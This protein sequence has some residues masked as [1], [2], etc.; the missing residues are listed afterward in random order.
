MKCRICGNE[1]NS[2][3]CDSCGFIEYNVKTHGIANL[4]K[5][6]GNIDFSEEIKKVITFFKR[7][8][9]LFNSN[10]YLARSDYNS[11]LS[12]EKDN[13]SFFEKL[14]KSKDLKN[15]CLKFNFDSTNIKSYIELNKNFYKKVEEKNNDFIKKELLKRKDYFDNALKASNPSIYLDN[16]QRE[17][18]IKNEDYNLVVA[19]AGAGKTTTVEGK[20][21]YL[22]DILKVKPEDILLISFTNKAV[23]ELRERINDK[24]AIHCTI[25][26]F[27]STGVDV[28]K[29]DK[30]AQISKVCTDPFFPINDFLTKKVIE[31]KELLKKLVLMFGYYVNI[32]L[33]LIDGLSKEEYFEINER[34]DYSTL[35]SNLNE[36]VKKAINNVDKKMVTLQY[37]NVKSYQEVQIANFLYLNSIEYEYEKIYKYKIPNARKLY[38]PDFYIKQGDKE[39]YIEHFGLSE[40]GKN[41][42][43]S[44]EE[45]RKYKEEMNYKIFHH[46]NFGTN[47]ICTYSKYNDG[48]ELIDH[49]KDELIKAGFELKPRNDNEIYEKIVKIEKDK[50]VTSF[51]NL[52]SDFIH[53]FKAKGY[54][55]ENFAKLKLKT[56]NPRNLLFLDVLER[57]YLNYQGYLKENQAVD[58][59]DMINE[60]TRILNRLSEEGKK[61]NYKYIIVDEYQDISRQRFNL[62][63][64]LRKVCNAKIMAVGDD[65]QSIYAFS[66]SELPLFTKF[67]E[68]VG[69]ASLSRITKTYRNS[70]ELIDIAG[71]FIQK[72]D[73]QYKKS[74]KSDKHISKPVVVCTYNDDFKTNKKPGVAGVNLEKAKKVVEMIEKIVKVDGPKT[75]ILILGRYGFDEHFLLKSELFAKKMVGKE[76]KI[77]AVKYPKIL[78]TYMTAH[79][80]KGLTY[81]NVIIINAM[82]SKYGFPAQIEN[83]PIM[84]FVTNNDRSYDFAE[85]RR[86][87][88]VAMTRTKNRVFI[89]TPINNPSRFVIE[90]LND[91]KNVSLNKT[92][93]V[94]DE[95]SMEIKEIKKSR[96]YCPKCGYPL[97]LRFNEAYGLKLYMCTNDPEIC[98]FMTNNIKGNGNIHL[99]DKC[100]G[101]MIVKKKKGIDKF[102]MGCTNYKEDKTGCN[103]TEEIEL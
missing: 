55:E 43:F 13:I 18:I 67:E 25:S 99:C 8:N 84:S 46:K 90:L 48:R 102:F 88:Y 71:N 21:K 15:Y 87:F 62:L 50:Y 47:L 68:E 64:A 39:Y 63:Q 53:N 101:Y 24:L 45:V 36:F 2:N 74:L 9:I 82:N 26:T 16:E 100:D 30:N 65:W 37:E 32:P 5:K 61:L 52:A 66:G 95:I 12:E 3:I 14:I 80:S 86:L 96:K 4:F 59:Q 38:T 31:D 97:Q 22:V 17:A 10:K 20:V 91:Y 77:Y 81:D 19:G 69:Y 54:T 94:Q 56:N 78:M 60:S 51:A 83:D 35:K 89:I 92:D 57:V 11:L 58:F 85:E 103:N 6:K 98:D 34:S 72:N 41:S 7:T 29:K 75:N 28:I 33:D 40:D 1:L 27:H 76:E 49:L 79:S 44:Q 42:R 70:Q 73:S 23:R 93:D